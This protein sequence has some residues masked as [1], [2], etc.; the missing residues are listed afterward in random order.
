MN[1]NLLEVTLDQMS[2]DLENPRFSGFKS[3]RDALT[4]I[5]SDQGTKLLE[6]AKDIVDQGLNPANRLLVIRG[7]SKNSFVVLDGN[8]RFCALKILTNPTVV[9]GIDGISASLKTGFK[10]QA[11]KFDK[12]TVDPL[13]VALLD[14]RE[15]ANQWIDLIHT[16]ENKGRGLVGW[17]GPAT[18]RF[19]GGS[20]SY[21]LLKLLN[22]ANYLTDEQA[23]SFPITNLARL[24]GT[25]EVREKLGITIEAGQPK[26]LYEL[27]DLAPLL[28]HVAQQLASSDITVSDIKNVDDRIAYAENLP[29]KLFP[30]TGALLS[31]PMPVS[32][33]L[34]T[35]GSG[36]KPAAKKSNPSSHTKPPRKQLIPRSCKLVVGVKKIENIVSELRELN[37]ERTP[38]AIAVLFRVFIELTMD[39][40]AKKNKIAGFNPDKDNLEN[41]VLKIADYL[42]SVG[43]TK[44]ELHSF[45]RVAG[46]PQSPLYV[47]RL[48]KFVHSQSSM[49]TASELRTGWDEVQEVF[50]KIWE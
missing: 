14:S 39:A 12:T 37:L 43:M 25:K 21:Q 11:D 41:K 15:E 4:Q 23:E 7:A 26:L 20:P 8:R 30:K 35:L 3:T 50:E 33:V 19:R 5:V 27:K 48:H 38:T 16:G 34:S 9:D 46:N 40:Y 17:D 49:P 10:K 42:Q 1:M 44:N 31:T 45:R 29:K 22:A 13:Q 6:L 18:D 36:G 47:E 2:L 32:D 24:L 28:K